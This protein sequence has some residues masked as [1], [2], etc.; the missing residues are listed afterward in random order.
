MTTNQSPLQNE[1]AVILTN[2]GT[3]TNQCLP[4][5]PI[6]NG[7][8]CITEDVVS[9]K[10][11]PGLNLSV[12]EAEPGRVPNVKIN[13]EEEGTLVMRAECV[14]ITDEG[15][16]VP[17]DLPSQE[18]QQE[19]VQ[20]EE[21]PKTEA[22]KESDE[23]VEAV[24]KTE[25]ALEM[26]T[27]LETTETTVAETQPAAEDEADI[28]TSDDGDA[29]TDEQDKI[30]EHAISAQSHSPANA[31]EGTT[32]ASV[33][34]YSET[35]PSSPT[36]EAEGEAAAS[37]VGAGAALNAEDVST[38]SG[39]FQEVPLADPQENHSAEPEL[40][41]QEPLL[42]QSKAHNTQAVAN[43]PTSTE[44]HIPAR[45]AQGEESAAPS[46]KSCQCCSVM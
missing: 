37:P 17:E 28:K 1:S 10:L 42:T 36:P 14:I 33:P 41:E 35:E 24:L 45:A 8:V 27:H 32:V 22:S 30:L 39:Q 44:T 15:D 31:P 26:I 20:A 13:E 19:T 34:V 7:P 11:E 12:S 16:D 5:Q 38:T 25:A 18:D 29:K 6:T 40:V 21:S 3:N 23:A 43:S 46:R 9:V 4:T 2:G